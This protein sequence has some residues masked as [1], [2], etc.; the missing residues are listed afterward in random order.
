MW[1]V[2]QVKG[3]NGRGFFQG[4]GGGRRGKV[5]VVTLSNRSV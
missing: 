3:E 5:G 4:R 2:T 1:G